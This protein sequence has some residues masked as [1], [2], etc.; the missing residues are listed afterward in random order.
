M[1]VVAH[2]CTGAESVEVNIKLSVAFAAVKPEVWELDASSATTEDSSYGQTRTTRRVT[3][4]TSGRS[5][6]QELLTPR[7]LF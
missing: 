4:E 7:G 1:A 6:L 2:C 3:W 5:P